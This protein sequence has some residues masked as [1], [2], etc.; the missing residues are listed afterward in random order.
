MTPN[1]DANGY[2]A[3]DV[4]LNLRGTVMSHRVRGVLWGVQWETANLGTRSPH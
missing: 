4:G 1:K 3:P 2:P